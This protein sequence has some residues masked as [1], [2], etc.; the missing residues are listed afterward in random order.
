MSSLSVSIIL[1][2]HNGGE[3]FCQC[4]MS[5]QRVM[6]MAEAIGELDVVIIVDGG[7]DGSEQAAQAFARSRNVQVL[8]RPVAAGPAFARNLGAKAARGEVLFFMDAD[9]TLQPDTLPQVMRIFQEQPDLAAL[10]GSYDDAP[11]ARNFLSQYKNLLHHYTHQTS[12]EIASTFWGACGAMRRDIFLRI[13]GFDESYRYPS[14]ED[15]ELGYRLKQAGYQIKLCKSVQVKHLKRWGLVSLLRAEIF[16][17][18]IPWTELIWR[19]G[20]LLNDLNLNRSSR[21]SLLL[22][23][24]LVGAV[25]LTGWWIQAG[26]VAGLIGFFLLWINRSVYQFFW[27][28]RGFWFACRTVPWHWFYFLYGGFAFAVGTIR[29]RLIGKPRVGKAMAIEAAESL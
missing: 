24:G 23:G 17:R 15:I 9:V 19:D 26:L 5:L 27:Q 22:T 28:K 18:A 14:V 12:N 1:P 10:I 2:V 8:S 6:P 21:V 20:K 13:G 3:T 4:L 16:Y 29:Y 7:N 11:G 25:L